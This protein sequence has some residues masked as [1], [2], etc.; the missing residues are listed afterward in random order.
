LFTTNIGLTSLANLQERIKEPVI[1]DEEFKSIGSSPVVT[2]GDDLIED[3]ND[4]LD[5]L[6]KELN[7]SSSS[8]N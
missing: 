8:E 5:E 7:D 1:D 4:D 6:E 3:A 2:D